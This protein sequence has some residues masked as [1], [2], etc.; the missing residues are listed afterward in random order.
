MNKHVYSMC[1]GLCKPLPVRAN[2]VKIVF[3][4]TTFPKLW[5]IFSSFRLKRSKVFG[6]V[7]GVVRVVIIP[8]PWPPHYGSLYLQCLATFACRTREII[9][10]LHI[11]IPYTEDRRPFGYS[12]RLFF[13]RNMLIH[14]LVKAWALS[15][16]ENC[17]YLKQRTLGVD[18]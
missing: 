6:F 10:A 15:R 3:Y 8:D 9:S 18:D 5:K 12:S 2:S 1:P 4:V 14:K 7:R 17:S 11:N 13:Y 16:V